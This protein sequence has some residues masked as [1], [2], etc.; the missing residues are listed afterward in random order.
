MNKRLRSLATA[1]VIS[2]T[3]ALVLVVTSSPANAVGTGYWV[4][5]TVTCSDTGTGTQAAPFCTI[6]QGTKK[7]V[8][9]GDTVHVAPGTYREQVTINASGTA[10]D[11]ITVVGDAPGVIVLGTRSLAGAALWTATGTTA[12]ST[13][14][15]PPSAPKQVFV[16]N[17]RLATATSA[18][19]TTPNSWFYDGTAK[20][21]YVDIGGA[22]PGDGHQVEAGA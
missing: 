5:N 7:A 15:A 4:N 2:M 8:L 9:P 17:Q 18:T 1:T 6:S 22:N 10:T 21:L 3:A 13:P 11:P 16:D 14:Y 12:W 19:T 20:V